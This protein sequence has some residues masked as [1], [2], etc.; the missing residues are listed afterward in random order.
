MKVGLFDHIEHADKPLH[1]LYDERLAFIA[2]ADEAGYWGYHLAEHHCSPINMVPAPG[3]FLGAMARST[4]RIKIGTLVYLLTLYSPLKLMEEI[5]MLD[6]LSNGRMEVGVGRGVSPF[7]LN[8]HKVSFDDSRE[9]F[10]DAYHCLRAA[11]TAG[12]TF[13]YSGKH[14][15]Y[16]DVPVW[17]RPQQQP[18]PAFWY[19]SSNATG[20][21]WAG[22]HGLHFTANGPTPMARENL[23]IYKAALAKRGGVEQPKAEFSWPARSG[24]SADTILSSRSGASADAMD[25]AAIGVLREIVVADTDREAERI[26]RPAAEEHLHNLNWLRG[27]HGAVDLTNRLRT[28]GAAKYEDVVREGVMIVGSP[29]TVVRAIEKQ[30]KELGGVNYLLAYMMFGKMQLRDALRSLNLFANEVMPRIAKL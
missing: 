10:I 27:K 9:I 21:T 16:K 11:L 7:E 12:E 13:S 6:H 1:T 15:N 24:A 23:D 25:G 19:G 20:S 3:A 18:Y 22:Q 8:Y 2:A 29:D 5:C 17:L 14:F 28:A 30:N 26:A 4:K